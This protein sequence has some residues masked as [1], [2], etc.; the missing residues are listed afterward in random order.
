MKLLYIT[1]LSGK[2]VNGFMRSAILAATELGIDFTMACNMDEA[3][4]LGYAADCKK[5]GIH[6]VHVDFDRNPLGYKNLLAH[7]QLNKIVHD[8]KYDVIHCNTPIGGVL[9][10]LCGWEQK[11]PTVI[12]QAHGF[13]FYQGA[14]LTNW[15]LYYPVE[16]LLAHWTDILITINQEDY[17][18]AQKFRLRKGGRVVLHPGVGVD[19]KS[20]AN[21]VVDRDAKRKE[22]GIE[23]KVAFFAAGTLNKN[24]NHTILIDAIKKM[25]RDDVALLIAG[26]GENHKKLQHKIDDLGL[27]QQVKLLGFRS[28]IKEILKAVDCFV[29]PSLREGLAMSAVEAVASGL[30]CVAS[31]N[32]GVREVLTDSPFLFEPHD[33]KTLVKHMTA[34]LD[35]TTRTQEA[36]RAQLTIDQFD[37]SKSIEHY[38]MIYHSIPTNEI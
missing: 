15:L 9:G 32:R 12:Y 5:Y 38:K 37:I 11:V 25:N 14:P 22:L 34:M 20:F 4:K 21:E 29:F 19:I 2:R 8:G 28:D 10:R 31:N 18:S 30:P 33:C 16:R 23:D 7:K 27:S 26:E 3:D 24:K 36:E 35:S 6:T 17:K 1:S 13:H